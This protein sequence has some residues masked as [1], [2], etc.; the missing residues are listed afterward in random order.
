MAARL[1]ELLRQQGQVEEQMDRLL[2]RLLSAV[3]CKAVEKVTGKCPEKL[4]SWISRNGRP[5]A[6][7]DGFVVGGER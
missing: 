7:E 1:V 5:K 6:G 2:I 4:E 3:A